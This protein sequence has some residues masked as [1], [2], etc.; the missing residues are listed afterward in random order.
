MVIADPEGPSS[1]TTPDTTGFEGLDVGDC[2][3]DTLTGFYIV[4]L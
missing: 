3:K 2:Q 1:A 4:H